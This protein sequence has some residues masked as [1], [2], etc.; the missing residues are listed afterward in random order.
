MSSVTCSRSRFPR[1]LVTATVAAFI[2][3]TLLAGCEPITV[4][5]APDGRI[6]FSRE[7]GVFVVDLAK[8]QVQAI[9]RPTKEQG[10]ASV[11]S[12][13]PDGSKLAYLLV[14]GDFELQYSLMVH[15]TASNKSEKVYAATK[16]VL[17]VHWSP[18]GKWLSV[19]E[20]APSDDE[21][22]GHLKL[23]SLDG[24]TVKTL[25]KQAS[26]AHRWTADGKWVLAYT[27]DSKV[28]DRDVYKGAISL[29]EVESGKPTKL[30]STVSGKEVYCDVTADG[31]E[32]VFL[33]M[34][35]GPADAEAPAPG[36]GDEQWAFRFDGKTVTKLW[37]DATLFCRFSPDGKKVL[38]MAGSPVNLTIRDLASGKD[39]TL[40]KNVAAKA[41]QELVSVPVYPA[42][43]PNGR[44]FYWKNKTT[45]GRT[46][47]ALTAFTVD[48]EGKSAENAQILIDKLV[49]DAT[50][51]G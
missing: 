26:L 40:D 42:F 20:A 2:G 21:I 51:G 45:Y 18:D 11:V 14:K 25:A 15:D 49:H 9:A 7:E 41:S 34:S 5:V 28:G 10:Q 8:G 47:S 16:P 37:S 39:T 30:A 24:K 35:A 29:I 19:G 27:V 38:G 36:D 31:K 33:A 3:A 4:S 13:S 12:F 6:A 48:L 22:G 46:G 44:V 17:H 43:L 23:V 50:K 32:A 1:F